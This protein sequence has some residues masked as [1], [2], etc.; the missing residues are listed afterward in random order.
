MENHSKNKELDRLAKFREFIPAY[1]R[2]GGAC[3]LQIN[4]QEVRIQ[5]NLV[6]QRRFTVGET[7]FVH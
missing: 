4:F 5:G 1:D 3:T 2:R 7:R 6:T